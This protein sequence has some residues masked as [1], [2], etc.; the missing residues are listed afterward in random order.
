MSVYEPSGIQ[1][2]NFLKYHI[3]KAKLKFEK[4]CLE[5]GQFP[6]KHQ[7]NLK[8][9]VWEEVKISLSSQIVLTPSNCKKSC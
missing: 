2:L 6:F 5:K 1:N 8:R 4:Y 7:L 9:W 3:E